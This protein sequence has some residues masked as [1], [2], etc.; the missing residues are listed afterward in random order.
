V[1]KTATES[2][3][4]P[5]YDP[6]LDKRVDAGLGA[7]GDYEYVKKDECPHC[8]HLM[9]VR[10]EPGIVIHEGADRVKVR[11]RPRMVGRP[12]WGDGQD[13]VEV[14]QSSVQFRKDELW[15]STAPLRRRPLQAIPP[16]DPA[17]ASPT[18]AWRR[19]AQPATATACCRSIGDTAL[20][21]E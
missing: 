17:A 14:S 12:G 21:A 10:A 6:R 11:S 4:E 5:N 1:S 18:R 8:K 7:S 15:A 9:T 3:W 19:R 2:M 20:T 13:G 16:E